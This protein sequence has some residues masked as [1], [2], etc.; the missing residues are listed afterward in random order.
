LTLANG[1]GALVSSETN[2]PVP[3]NF[4]ISATGVSYSIVRQM[5]RRRIF[6][7]FA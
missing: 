2:A 6:V 5:M 4:V 1:T 3:P 7:C